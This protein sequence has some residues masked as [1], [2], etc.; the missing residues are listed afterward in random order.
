M[1]KLCEEGSP[2]HRQAAGAG[3]AAV[4]GVEEAGTWGRVPESREKGVTVRNLELVLYIFR[5]LGGDP[6]S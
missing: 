1:A 5:D 3:P 2:G 4:V 6:S